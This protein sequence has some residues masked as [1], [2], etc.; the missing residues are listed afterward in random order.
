MFN[1]HDERAL[2][3]QTLLLI[4]CLHFSLWVSLMLKRPSIAASQLI[5]M[6]HL[7]FTFFYT[8]TFVLWL[9]E[10]ETPNETHTQPQ[11]HIWHKRKIWLYHATQDAS[12]MKY[13]PN[14]VEAEQSKNQEYFN[15]WCLTVRWIRKDVRDEKTRQKK[16]IILTMSQSKTKKKNQ[17]F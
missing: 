12:Q 8:L 9:N 17:T 11:Q 15:L 6:S 7:R 1:H 3:H 14:I 13:N 5:I 2:K 10:N 16:W 4:I